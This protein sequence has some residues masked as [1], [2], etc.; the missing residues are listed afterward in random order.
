MKKPSRGLYRHHLG[1]SF[2]NTE[3]QQSRHFKKKTGL[4]R[5]ETNKYFKKTESS[6]LHERING[7]KL[8]SPL[9]FLGCWVLCSCDPSSKRQS[10]KLCVVIHMGLVKSLLSVA[11]PDYKNK[12]AWQTP[13]WPPC[14]RYKLHLL[15]QLWKPVLGKHL[16]GSKNEATTLTILY[17]KKSGNLQVTCSGK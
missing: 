2:S 12:K 7:F 15:C 4:S 5:R 14:T 17:E 1:S 16:G 8:L 10:T 11:C 3:K 9:S 13:A 6:V